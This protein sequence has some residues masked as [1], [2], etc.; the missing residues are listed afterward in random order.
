MFFFDEGRIKGLGE[1]NGRKE[2]DAEED[3]GEDVG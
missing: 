2:E 1:T 3:G